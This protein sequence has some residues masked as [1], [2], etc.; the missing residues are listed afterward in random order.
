PWL[1]CLSDQMQLIYYDQLG[2]GRST[3]PQS[4]EGIGLD[5]WADEADALR[6]T[7][8]HDRIIL[9]GHSF[10]GFLAQEYALRY[11]DHLDGL[12]LCNTAPVLDYP[13]VIVGN[14]QARG[15]PE[16]VQTVIRSLSHPASLTDDFVWRQ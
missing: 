5:T 13:Q 11:G 12:I 16:Q 4:Y 3:R 2:N 6:A 10:G 15:T 7:L 14:A 9:F 8:G 1:D